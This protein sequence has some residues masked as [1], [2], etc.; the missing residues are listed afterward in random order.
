MHWKVVGAIAV[1]AQTKCLMCRFYYFKM[2]HFLKRAITQAQAS[3]MQWL[4]GGNL[5]LRQ[6]LWGQERGAHGWSTPQTAACQTVLLLSFEVRGAPEDY[7]GQGWKLLAEQVL[8]QV[9]IKLPYILLNQRDP[10]GGRRSMGVR[11]RRPVWMPKQLC[12]SWHWLWSH[13]VERV[14]LQSGIQGVLLKLHLSFTR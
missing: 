3:K 12:K 2:Y 14:C 13:Q 7:Q 11:Q 9:L 5:G 4:P 8:W 10:W 1:A 6:R